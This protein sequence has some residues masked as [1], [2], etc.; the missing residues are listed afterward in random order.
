MKC[1]IGTKEEVERSESYEDKND[2]Y[3][4]TPCLEYVEIVVFSVSSE[5]YFIP[6]NISHISHPKFVLV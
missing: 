2:R 1:M 5:K 6:E 4:L 3:G